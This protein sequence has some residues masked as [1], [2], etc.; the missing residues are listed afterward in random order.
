MKTLKFK[1]DLD[2]KVAIYVPST[3]DVNVPVDN[4]AQVLDVI[5]ELSTI[6]GGATATEAV[7]GWVAAS[8]ETVIEH[9][10]IVYSFAS[11]EALR[12]NIEK[13]L[14][15]CERLKAEMSQEAIT[16]EINGQVKFV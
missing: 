8:G 3:T 12:N 16:L 11:S 10:T 7:G 5:R 14:S 2:S 15:I 13:V 6:F 1:F 9:V 4:K